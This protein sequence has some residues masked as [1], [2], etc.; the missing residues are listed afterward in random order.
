[1]IEC[2]VNAHVK[3]IASRNL[4][5]A[6]DEWHPVSFAI[7]DVSKLVFP[8]SANASVFIRTMLSTS[9][10]IHGMSLHQHIGR[11]CDYLTDLS[12]CGLQT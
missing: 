10:S 6:W 4:C 8:R 5:A 7:W 2:N 11:L 9:T 3:H 12:K 1:M